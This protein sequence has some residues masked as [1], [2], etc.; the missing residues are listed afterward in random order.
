MI[1]MESTYDWKKNH[2]NLLGM[3]KNRK[4]FEDVIQILNYF[5]L[6]LSYER[7][8]DQF[9]GILINDRF[10]KKLEEIFSRAPKLLD[11]L[12]ICHHSI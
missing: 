4:T 7:V 9:N 6:T 12:Y 8:S 10:I 1:I 2:G 3:K 5:S 11:S